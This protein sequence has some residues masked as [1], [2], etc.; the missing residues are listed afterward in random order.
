MLY[1]GHL[2]QQLVSDQSSEYIYIVACHNWS[3]KL[4]T[5]GGNI[6]SFADT[7]AANC[8]ILEN[9]SLDQGERESGL[10]G[11]HLAFTTG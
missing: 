8:V 9:N 3:Q 10:W 5:T 7:F 6:S 2:K 1:L 11:P 4:G